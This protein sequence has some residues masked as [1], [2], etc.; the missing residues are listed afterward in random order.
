[1][2]KAIGPSIKKS[3]P[4]KS[5]SGQPILD[6][7]KQVDRWVEHYLEL[8]SRETLLTDEALNSMEPLPTLDHLDEIPTIAEV[9][10]AIYA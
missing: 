5:T 7:G 6:K 10:V 3:A 4:L 9:K 8:Y 1:M 2:K